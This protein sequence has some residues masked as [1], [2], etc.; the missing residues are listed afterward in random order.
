MNLFVEQW[1]ITHLIALVTM[2][3]TIPEGKKAQIV[4]AVCKFVGFKDEGLIESGS[5]RAAL[6]PVMLLGVLVR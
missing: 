6:G 3:I 2:K 5:V 4:D 1:T